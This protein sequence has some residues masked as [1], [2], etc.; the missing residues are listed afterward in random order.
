MIKRNKITLIISS[1]VILLPMLIGVLGEK[2]LPPEIAVHWGF[3]GEADGFMRPSVAFLILPLILLA[4]HWLCAILVDVFDKRADEQNIKVQR[5]VL[6]ILPVISFAVSGM[7]LMVALGYTKNLVGFI[8]LFFGALF[9]AIGNYMPKMSRSV[10][11]GIKIKWTLA[12]E[13]NW[14]ATHRFAGKVYVILGFV[15]LLAMPLPMKAFPF[16]IVAIILL[17][18]LLPIIYSYRFYQKQLAEGKVTKEDCEKGYKEIV[19]NPK[20]ARVIVVVASV[21][22]A[23]F[24]FLIMFTGKI[25]IS[26]GDTS[27]T[28]DATF[29]QEMTIKYEDIDSVELREEKI[30]GMKVGGFNS[31]KLLL[32]SFQN[33]E[34]GVFTRYTYTNCHT[35]IVLRVDERVIVINEK[36]DDQTRAL[37]AELLLKMA[38]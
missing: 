7:M 19:K 4:A 26:V 3:S 30:G 9:I 28:L 16:V 15:S 1:L 12:N 34:F 8:F 6:W 29:W 2:I 27:L 18:V 13:E 33:E 24:L 36:T 17:C 21:L 31:A 11:M 35:S 37:Y 10:T 38:R 5:L 20:R 22:L 25:E 23:I 14:N 32:G